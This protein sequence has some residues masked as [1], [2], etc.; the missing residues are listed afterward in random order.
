[1][2]NAGDHP[3]YFVSGISKI[4]LVTSQKLDFLRDIIKSGKLIRLVFSVFQRGLL[5]AMYTAFLLTAL[6]TPADLAPI[7]VIGLN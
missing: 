3:F 2:F 4:I 1:M 5:P 6:L 7:K